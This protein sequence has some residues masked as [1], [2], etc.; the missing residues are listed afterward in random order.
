MPSFRV[1]SLYLIFRV[2]SLY[3]IFRVHYAATDG[4]AREEF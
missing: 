4:W 3:L 2:Y 1:Y